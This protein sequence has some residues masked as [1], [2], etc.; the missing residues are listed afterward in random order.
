MHRLLRHYCMDTRRIDRETRRAGWYILAGFV[1]GVM[2]FLV[3]GPGILTTFMLIYYGACLGALEK[4]HVEPGLWMLATVFLVIGASIY[5]L[6]QY[7]SLME[8]VRG[9]SSPFHV[10]VDGM[11]A[12][13]I[14]WKQIRLLASVTM[15]NHSLQ[16]P[17][18]RAQT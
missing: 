6:F 10:A 15:Q 7:N 1:L 11:V 18:D 5:V 14:L 2:V 13:S 4:W 12:L 17:A 9:K 3:D 16:R 8:L